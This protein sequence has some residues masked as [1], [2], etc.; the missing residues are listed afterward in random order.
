MKV[1]IT[2][3]DQKIVFA[4]FFIR[5]G[6]LSSVLSLLLSSEL[7]TVCLLLSTISSF[8]LEADAV[9]YKH[10]QGLFGKLDGLIIFLSC[11]CFE[12]SIKLDSCVAVKQDNCLKF[13]IPHMGMSAAIFVILD[14]LGFQPPGKS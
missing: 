7:S 5:F 14:D 9:E 11:A 10:L 6:F 4:Y 8:L 13:L 2:A 3:L 1:P 12:K